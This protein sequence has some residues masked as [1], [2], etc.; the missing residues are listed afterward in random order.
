MFNAWTIGKMRYIDRDN[1][2][3]IFITGGSDDRTVEYTLAAVALPKLFVGPG[4]STGVGDPEVRNP[5]YSRDWAY[6]TKLSMVG[7][8]GTLTLIGTITRDHEIDLADPDAEGSVQGQCLDEL[9]NEIDGCLHDHGVETVSRYSNAAATLAYQGLFSDDLLQLDATVAVSSSDVNEDVTFN[10][11]SG[12]EG[13]SPIVYDDVSDL[14]AVARLALF[15]PFDMGLTLR[16]EAFSVGEH[17][18]AIFGARREADVLLTEGFVGGGQLPTLNL[19]NEFM[20]FD[21][22]FVESCIGWYGGTLQPTW[23]GDS[24]TLTGEAT[25][26]GYHTDG[27]ERDVENVYPDFLHADGFTDT[28]LY[29]Y[30]NTFDRGRDPRSVFRRNQARTT[31][32]A[33]MGARWEPDWES[34]VALELRAKR[35]LDIDGRSDTTSLD[36]YRGEALVALA[37]ADVEAAQGLK[38]RGGVEVQRWDERD[39]RGTLELGYGDDV[40]DKA[41]AFLGGSYLFEGWKLIY[42]MEYLYKDQRREREPDQVWH[43][44]RSKASLEVKW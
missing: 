43:V 9:G 1:G 24:V 36:D 3:G 38:L 19:A 27:Q 23:E 35:I 12:N 42:R 31:F 37:A 25:Y 11:V 17:F 26:I 6:A 33:A 28:D 15:E 4:W 14:A 41:K 44:V 20:D 7:D 2:K 13:V 30:A 22:Q 39:R 32:I 40:T 18:N 16:A 10:G 5:F 34:P 29:D 21:E 8:G